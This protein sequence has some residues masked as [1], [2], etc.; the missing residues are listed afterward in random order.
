MIQKNKIR[1]EEIE[2]KISDILDTVEIIRD[3]LPDTYEEFLALGLVKDGL[4]KKA[5]YA[6]ESV[7]DICNILNSDMRLGVPD[8][9]DSLLDNLEKNK[10]F[11]KNIIEL[12]R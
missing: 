8:T 2:K 9:E 11:N 6:L 1:T 10:V 3:N 4:Y 12:I 5:E 7:I